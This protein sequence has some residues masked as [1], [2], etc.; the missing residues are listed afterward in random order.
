MDLQLHVFWDY[1]KKF[2]TKPFA[3]EFCAGLSNKVKQSDILYLKKCDYWFMIISLDGTLSYF[4]SDLRI[5]VYACMTFILKK[6]IDGI[7]TVSYGSHNKCNCEF[8]NYLTISTSHF[9]I[10]GTPSGPNSICQHLKHCNCPCYSLYFV[11]KNVLMPLQ[12]ICFYLN[13]FHTCCVAIQIYIISLPSTQQFTIYK[14][15]TS[16]NT[17]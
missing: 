9:S 13:S 2:N 8:N 5:S 14:M 10:T 4:K 3:G 16:S 6:K 7:C 12:I 1:S 17:Y 15:L 11:R